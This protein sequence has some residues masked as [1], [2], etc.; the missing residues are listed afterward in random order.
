MRT[1]VEATEDLTER[2][3]VQGEKE[4]AEHRILGNTIGGK[5]CGGFTDVF[6]YEIMSVVE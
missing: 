2:G 5:D 4:G 1:N 6:D 3:Y